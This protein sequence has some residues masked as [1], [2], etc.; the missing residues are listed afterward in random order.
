[1]K[2]ADCGY[3]SFGS[4]NVCPKCGAAFEAGKS[5]GIDHDIEKFELFENDEPI[6]LDEEFVDDY[7][8]HGTPIK[9]SNSDKT[10]DSPGSS[11][12]LASF[13]RRFLAFFIDISIVL[14]VS[15]LTIVIG[16]LAGGIEINED[17]MKFTY[18]LLPVYLILS[19]LASTLLLFLH[20]YSGKS[21]GKLIFGIRVV[22]EDGKSISLGQSFTRWVG[23]YISA[24]PALYGYISALFDYNLQTWH[25]KISKT[26]VIRDN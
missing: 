18:I 22:R 26:C 4:F 23:Y 10:N 15:F 2:C 6:L 21:F 19:L 13:I 12:V 17:V 7:S 16:L 3:N 24:L 1:M 5:T 11:L 25:D 14:A 9:K 8:S 20:A